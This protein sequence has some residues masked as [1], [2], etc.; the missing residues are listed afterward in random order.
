MR[1]YSFIMGFSVRMTQ[2]STRKYRG[3]FLLLV[4]IFMCSQA[5]AQIQFQDKTATAGPFHT[6]ESWG[7]SWGHLNDDLYPDMYVSNHGMPTSVYRNNGDG[8]F[9]DV[10][11]A[12][13]QEGQLT[14]SAINADIHGGTWADYDND[15]DDDLFVSRSNEGARVFL[16]ENDGNG[17]FTDVGSVNGIAAIGTARLVI[18][19]DYD[20]DGK[21]DLSVGRTDQPMGVYQRGTNNYTNTS[22]TVGIEGECDRSLYAVPA[23]LF[24]NGNL[25]FNCM[26]L[27]NIP[28]R[29]YDTS[30]PT[31]TDVNASINPVGTFQDTAVIDLDNNGFQDLV[32][33]RGRRIPS[34]AKLIDSNRIEAWLSVVSGTEKHFTFKSSGP[35]SVNLH[36]RK[37]G[38]RNK[39]S[40]SPNFNEFDKVFIGS[41]GSFPDPASLP[42]TL[43]PANT[44]H[45]GIAALNSLGAYMGYDPALQEWN[46]YISSIPSG[47]NE[48]VYITVDGTGLNSLSEVANLSG[49]DG[50]IAP[51]VLLN[52]GTDLIDS[53]ALGMAADTCGSVA[54][55]DFDND[56][57]VDLYMVCR[58][59]IENLE[60]RFYW[61]DGSGNF[62]LSTGHG[63][64]GPIGAGVL[65]GDGTG[66]IAVT[67]DYNLDGFMDLF[68]TNG[69]R[70]FPHFV[71]D[72]FTGGGPDQIFLNNADN[73]NNWLMFDLQGVQSN[74][75]GYGAKITVTAA[76]VTQFRE[77]HGRFHRNSHDHRRVHFGMGSNTT[78]TV[79]IE[80]PNGAVDVHNNVATNTLYNAVENGAL[81]DISGSGLPALSIDDISI[82]EGDTASL[83]VTLSPASA[84]TVTVDYRTWDSTAIAGSD[85]TAKVDSLTFSPNE[86][87]KTITVD[88]LQDSL[89][90]DDELFEVLLA[91]ASN[92]VITD[93]V[94]EVTIDNDDLF[95]G[96][97]A[98]IGDLTT[99]EG[100]PAQFVISLSQASTDTVTVD[101]QTVDGTATAGADYIARSGSIVF[102]PG[103]TIKTRTVTTVQDTIAEPIENF[104]MTL[105]N[106]V[107]ANLG[108]SVGTAVINDDDSATPVLSIDNASLTEGGTA[109]LNVSLSLASSSVVTVDYQTADGSAIAGSDYT[110][111]TGTLTFNPNE[112]SKTIPV[113]TLQDILVEPSEHFTVVLSNPGNATI[114]DAT[115]D[116]TINDDDA[117]GGP[118][119]SI[120]DLTVSEGGSAV[121][122][123]TLS[124]TANNTVTVSYQTNDGTA[125]SGSDYI[126]RSG[127]IVFNPGDTHKTRT[128]MIVQDSVTE[129]EEVF[130]MTLTNPVNATLGQSTGT[131]TVQDDDNSQGNV[132]GQPAID[133]SID[134]TLFLWKD[135]SGNGKWHVRAT[136]GGGSVL[137]YSGN[138][139]SDQTISGVTPFSIESS[140]T[141][142]S[143]A[144]EII[145]SMTMGSIWQDGFDFDV[146]TGSTCLNLNTPTGVD[147]LV[148]ANRTPVTPSFDIETLQACST[149]GMP[150]LSIDNASVT[151]GGTASLTVNLSSASSS[152]VTV[153]FQTVDGSAVTGSDYTGKSGSLTFNPNEVSKTIT[154]DTLQDVLVEAAENISVVLSNPVNATI[155]DT[156]G[157]ITINDDD[158]GQ[159]SVCGQPNINTSVDRSIFLWKD[160]TGNG[161][162]HVRA[163]AGD[164]SNK[165][166]RGDLSTNQTFNN[167][168]PFSLENSDSLTSTA[169][170]ITFKMMVSGVLQ[171]GFDFDVTTGNTCMTLS[172]PSG[173]NVLVG[174]TRIQVARPFDIET[175][176]DCQ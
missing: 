167:V 34:G 90:E 109:N 118:T 68:V 27:S 99:T 150:E 46:I 6:G 134:R 96:P 130:T 19:Y 7:A 65:G 82:T 26:D 43:D 63:A 72:G 105:T 107:N 140:D 123:I 101:Y 162:W 153:D 70:L 151:E 21:L 154:V 25:V 22:S 169:Q 62:T 141:L 137:T 35:I 176:G 59:A 147:V 39:E 55:E 129:S 115:G 83:T 85:Y 15:G 163:T 53:G 29:A 95:S 5:N 52:D 144:Q 168:A 94:A 78:A 74:R 16:F 36:S 51:V 164:G 97:T 133:T 170:T 102:Q 98:S 113:D 175:L 112:V 64:E 37:I 131:A 60:N 91:N 17:L 28:K 166:Y 11:A 146:V 100:G 31:W 114:A 41:T 24:N 124:A 110:S 57:D 142:T 76:G 14:G 75:S 67:A 2:I 12:A 61:N 13:I 49:G 132:C 127:N 103:D 3:V 88:T 158:G 111:K 92:A 156:T 73:G 71:K 160:C 45:H 77:Q 23:H 152:V 69:N 120:A 171:D 84:S 44:A 174:A 136:A 172:T 148:G 20:K 47:G 128:V 56:M 33:T 104:S 126:S 135:C 9:S 81:E 173:E 54:A 32:A 93:F 116:V 122:T 121:F 50:P 157:E 48:H 40:G 159:G 125:I 79:T 117:G 8:T 106:P 155:S 161:E 108:Q 1:D 38:T 80:W 138:I 10:T 149:G 87:S 66:D 89:F 42:V 30:T 145:F 119:L 4:A 58:T 143:T 86:T 18:V 139:S 165:R